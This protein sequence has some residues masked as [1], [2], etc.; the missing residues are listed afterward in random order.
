MK[1]EGE[2]DGLSCIQDS[3]QGVNPLIP[4]ACCGIPPRGITPTIGGLFEQ[5]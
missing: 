1:D 4:S 5:K 3:E 2:E